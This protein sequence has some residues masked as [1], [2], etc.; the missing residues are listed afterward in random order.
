MARY[1]RERDDESGLVFVFAYD[2]TD[3]E[4]LHI[5]ARHLAEP[6][7]AIATFFDGVTVYNRRYDRFETVTPTHLLTWFWLEPERTVMV[8]PCMRRD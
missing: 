6:A 7:D 4:L 1:Y 8:I 2:G 5:Y 3:P